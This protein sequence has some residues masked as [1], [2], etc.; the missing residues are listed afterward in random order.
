MAELDT[1]SITNPRD[2]DF[3]GRYNG[4][5]YR[6]RAGETKVY[7]KYLV[8]HLAKHLSN[9]MLD[10]ET[11][12]LIAKHQEASPFVPQVGILMNH[13]NPARRKYL[14]DILGSR[15]EVESCLKALGF[16]SFVGEMKE[17]DDY[18]ESKTRVDEEA[19]TTDEPQEKTPKV[20]QA[21]KGE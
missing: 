10:K 1:C 6:V 3:T 20:K 16:K 12:E 11:R 18:V 4:E 21:K 8:Y 15:E 13:D 14:F 19:T 7:P 9:E 17:Y 5:L 2:T